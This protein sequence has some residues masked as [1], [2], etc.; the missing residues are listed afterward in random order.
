MIEYYN[1]KQIKRESKLLWFTL[2]ESIK[3]AMAGKAWGQSYGASLAV[4]KQFDHILPTHSN[5]TERI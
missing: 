5:Q 3:C 1:Q 2:P 4:Q